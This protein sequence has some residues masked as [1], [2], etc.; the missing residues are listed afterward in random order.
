MQLDRDDPLARAVVGAIRA[1][2]I[3]ALQRLLDAHPG[4]A[5]ARIEDGAASRSLLHVAT[6]WPGHFPHVGRTVETLV[7]AGADANARFHGR[8]AET[9]LHWAASSDDVEALDA[10]LEAGAEID[11]DGAV[12]AGGTPL[13]DARIFGQWRAGRRLIERGARTTLD[14]E[15]AFGLLDRVR[16]AVEGGAV[17][18]DDLG[19]AFWFACHG[20]QHAVAAYLL[21]RGAALD[22]PAP[23]EPATPRD[24]AEREGHAGVAAW[25]RQQGARSATAPA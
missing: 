15:A 2:D 6:D 17:A 9:P 11:A 12:I 14:D 1:G 24:A 18:A 8:H 4:L 3:T 16:A 23:W 7:A 13:T 22:W 20:G 5:Q 10:L 19:R 21:A 25:L